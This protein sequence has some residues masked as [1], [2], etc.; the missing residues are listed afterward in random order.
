[1]SILTSASTT[2]IAPAL[3]LAQGEVRAAGKSGDNKF[4]RYTYS[5]LE[6]FLT[7]SRPILAKHGLSLMFSVCDHFNMPDRP[8]K[9]EGIE[10]CAQVTVVAR[11]THTSG[12]WVQVTGVG[13][14][15]D[16]A[17]KSLYKAITG[18]KKYLL[19]GL[20]AIPTTDDPEE[21]DHGEPAQAPP[22]PPRPT[23]TISSTNAGPVTMGSPALVTFPPGE[24]LHVGRETTVRAGVIRETVK[25]PKKLSPKER[26][27]LAYEAM[28]EKYTM[29]ATES[30][31]QEIKDKHLTVESRIKA[32]EEMVAKEAK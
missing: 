16:R 20:L 6:D 21:G 5:K 18:A 19:A 22:P 29:A 4:D 24:P 7:V 14:G 9:K 15:Q 3:A 28:C 26:Y 23:F 13:E 12:E 10:H 2:S 31:I 27:D 11:L 32:M 17:D 1:M 8:T 30:F 25:A